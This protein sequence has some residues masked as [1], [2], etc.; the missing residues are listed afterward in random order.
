M[1]ITRA[2]LPQ[3]LQAGAPDLRLTGDQTHR[4]TYTQRRRN[5][6]AGGGIASMR[7]RIKYNVGPGETLVGKPG[8]IVEPGVEQYGILSKIKDKIVDD[9]IPNEI[10]ENPVAAAALLGG[11]A[12]YVDLIPGEMSSEG[13]IGDLIGG[14]K[15]M[16]GMGQQSTIGNLGNLT[17]INMDPYIMGGGISGTGMEGSPELAGQLRNLINYTTGMQGSPELSSVKGQL[18]QKL[19]PEQF[20]GIT[21]MGGMTDLLSA[22]GGPG[23]PS[24]NIAQ[25]VLN[26]L[27]L[28]NQQYNSKGN[29][30]VNWR[31]PLAIG[32]AVGLADKLSR[33]DHQLPADLTIDPTRFATAQAAMDD[34]NLRFKPPL[35]ATQLAADGGRI[36]YQNAGPVDIPENLPTDDYLKKWEEFLRRREEYD[37]KI[38][39]APKQEVAQGGRIGY[40]YGE[41]VESIPTDQMQDIEGQTAMIT[42]KQMQNIDRTWPYLEAGGMNVQDMYDAAKVFDDTGSKGFWGVGERDPEPMTK[43]EFMEYMISKG[44]LK[45]PGKSIKDFDKIKGKAQGGRI[46]A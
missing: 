13:W 15:D 32:T 37:K 33:K 20:K 12:N 14:A 18:L 21:G 25:R 17:G 11:A 23:I 30:A 34:P 46:G 5:Q 39:M 44:Y 24:S 40:R 10:K 27:G 2:L 16:M 41:G 4:G 38:R 36:G 22:M 42:D 1:A 6:M 7:D 8:G 45:L 28:G 43:K 35:E 29:Q 9:L 31:G 19:L 26:S 3:Q